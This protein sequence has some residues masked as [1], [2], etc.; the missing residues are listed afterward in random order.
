MPFNMAW[1]HN[2]VVKICLLKSIV[3]FPLKDMLKI[4]TVIL[5][6]AYMLHMRDQNEC[7]NLLL[8]A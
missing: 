2:H 7:S 5:S 8:W 6:L 3:V 1:S 4:V